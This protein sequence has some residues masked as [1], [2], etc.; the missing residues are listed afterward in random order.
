MNPNYSPDLQYYSKEEFKTDEFKDFD[1]FNWTEVDISPIDTFWGYTLSLFQMACGGYT[2]ETYI[3]YRAWSY[4]KIQ[5]ILAFDN[6][7]LGLLF[8]ESFIILS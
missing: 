7:F 8:F 3:I 4:F 6:W 5:G 2:I 1:Y